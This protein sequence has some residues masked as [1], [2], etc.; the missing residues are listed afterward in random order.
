MNAGDTNT[1]Y[2]S[3][4]IF[5]TFAASGLQHGLFGSLKP[6]TALPVSR[7]Q[8]SG[9]EYFTTESARHF[10][11]TVTRTGDTSGTA[12][13]N[14]ATVDSSAS[15]KSNYEIALGRLTFNPGEASKTF[16][17][18][19]VD[20]DLAAAGTTH[21]LDLV[22]SNATGA[23]L[24][25]PAIA[26]LFIMDDEFDTPRQPPNIIDDTQF[27]VRQQYLIFLTANPTQP[28]STSG[29]TRSLPAGPISSVLSSSGSTS[30]QLSFSRLNFSGPACWLT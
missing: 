17:V 28:A 2:F 1:L 30:Q 11:V 24:V 6:V 16:R 13:V 4:G 25:N 29:S 12:T 21:D 26:K 3:A 8:F 18:L 20:D 9:K 19:I 7:I 5:N 23:A 10:D 27:F 14:Y 22:L 15:Q